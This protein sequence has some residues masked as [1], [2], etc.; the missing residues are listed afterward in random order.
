MAWYKLNFHGFAWITPKQVLQA[1]NNGVVSKLNFSTDSTVGNYSA[2]LLWMHNPDFGNSTFR[3]FIKTCF[4]QWPVCCPLY[5]PLRGWEWNKELSSQPNH[6]PSINYISFCLRNTNSFSA[7]EKFKNLHFHFEHKL[8][9]LNLD[10]AEC[11]FQMWAISQI[12]QPL[13]SLW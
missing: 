1:K 3:V 7:G 8:T 5:D 10:T 12:T 6:R 11:T 2:V 4:K 9:N 13:Q